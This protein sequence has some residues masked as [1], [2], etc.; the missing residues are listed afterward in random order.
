MEQNKESTKQRILNEALTLFSVKGY[1]PVTVAEI[2]KA[3]GIKAPSLYNHYKSKRDI[4]DAI[5]V[6]MKASYDR[7]ATAMQMDGR[8]ADKDKL[9]YMGAGEDGLVKMA[10]D[11]MRKI[12]R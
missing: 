5:L 10:V 8:N 4:F 2:A 11:F 3:V 6:E 12:T 9:L 7:Q 1:G